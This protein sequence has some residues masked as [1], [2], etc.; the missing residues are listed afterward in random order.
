M[1]EIRDTHKQMLY[2]AEHFGLKNRMNIC[3]EE[4]AE[5]IQAL[6][7]NQ[8]FF[9]NDVT[10]NK[11]LKEVSDNVIEE[12]ADV[13]ICL[14]QI[15]YLMGITQDVEEVKAEKIKRTERLLRENKNVKS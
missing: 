12:I 5:L 2:Q 9:E 11:T 15:K 7:K 8:R 3:I 1:N 13:E 6:C 14:K 4:C 10:M